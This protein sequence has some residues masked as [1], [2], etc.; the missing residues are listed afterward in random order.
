MIP[1]RGLRAGAPVERPA[2][3]LF[4]LIP[5]ADPPRSRWSRERVQ[6]LREL[7]L[8]G[9]PAREI[10]ARLG[11]GLSHDAVQCKAHR[12]DLPRR[13]NPVPARRP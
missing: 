2:L 7:W 13:P 4:K 11:P 1:I 8:A 12:L 10:A 3:V 9:L 5:R 6:L